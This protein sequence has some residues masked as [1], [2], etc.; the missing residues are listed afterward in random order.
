MCDLRCLVYVSAAT[1][2]EPTSTELDA[3][4]AHA[5]QTNSAHGVT[6]LLL[7]AGGNFMQLLEGEP[8]PVQ[9]TFDRIAASRRHKDIIV[10]MDETVCEREFPDWSMAFRPAEAAVLL[11]ARNVGAPT[12]GRDIMREMWRHQR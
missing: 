5:R 10:L 6:G 11:E 9:E 8:Q 4:L 12:A 3:L 1:A 7:H 2:D